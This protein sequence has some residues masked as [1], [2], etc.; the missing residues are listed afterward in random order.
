[1]SELTQ[2]FSGGAV[3]VGFLWY[4][5]NSYMNTR[6]SESKELKDLSM[7]NAVKDAIQDEKLKQLEIRVSKLEEK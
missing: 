4:A 7:D 6:K 5:F 3:I 2:Y 1:M